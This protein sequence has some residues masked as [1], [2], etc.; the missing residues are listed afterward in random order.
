MNI[1]TFLNHILDA[2]FPKKCLGCRQEGSFLCD[3]CFL[4]ITTTRFQV[5]PVCKKSSYQ[6]ATHREKCQSQTKLDGLLVAGS[7]RDNPVLA[8]AVKQ[9]KYRYSRDLSGQLGRLLMQTLRENDF[10]FQEVILVP[11]P[12]HRKRK[13]WRG[14]NQAQILAEEVS[15]SIHLPVLEVL[16]RLKNTKQQAK[17]NRTERL[18]NLQGAFGLMDSANFRERI[19]RS[20]EGKVKLLLVDD[21]SSTLV[22]LE[23]AAK[24]LK[25]AGTEEVW[26]LVLARG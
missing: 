26:G 14:F 25:E 15:G 1:P 18:Q 5:C 12:L 7:Y 16:E 23:E 21:V 8:A 6:G 20:R 2:L 11:V 9:F 13:N 17:L 19:S 24:V 3:P 10:P 4:K 22:T